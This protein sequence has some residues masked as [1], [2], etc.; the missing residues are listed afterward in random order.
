MSR[1]LDR[2]LIPRD[3]CSGCG[4]PPHRGRRC[5]HTIQVGLHNKRPVTEDC[6]CRW[7]PRALRGAL[8][9]L[10]VLAWAVVI[11]P[12][13]VYAGTVGR[14]ALDV[15]GGVAIYSLYA[16]GFLAKLIGNGDSP[17]PA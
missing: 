9:V 13:V 12:A 11:L 2:R 17:W 15:A 5:S 1:D 14:P 6:P 3:A 8:L 10:L 4:H 16:V 7:L